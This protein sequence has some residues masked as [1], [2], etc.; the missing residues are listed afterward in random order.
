[1][2]RK[3]PARRITRAGAVPTKLLLLAVLVAL[4]AA[5]LTVWLLGVRRLRARHAASQQPFRPGARHL[6]IGFITNFWDTFG[7]G[8]FA[9]TTAAFK[10]WRVV[11]DE[12][13]PGTLNVGHTLPTVIQALVFIVAIH[14]ETMT[15]A[16]MIA[17]A[18][19]GAW[20]GAGVVARLARRN[21]QIGMGV[22]L[23]GAAAIVLAQLLALVPSGNAAALSGAKL[24]I[25][26]ST[27]AVLGALMT[28][29]VGLYAPCMVLV[30]LLGMDPAGAFP[31]M[32]GSCAFLMPVAGLRF[33]R[34]D[35][36]DVRAALGLTLG[37]PIAVLLAIWLLT[38]LPT[39][40]VRAL[41]FVVILYNAVTMLRSAITESR[42]ERRSLILDAE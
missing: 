37:G 20:F 14:V 8:S 2:G 23:L 16:L 29:G 5:F 15:L 21:V 27:N 6:G 13:I 35:A 9:T 22:A 1:M 30:S 36:Y 10:L 39:T 34:R 24:A 12:Q 7:I 4:T 40:V 31:I 18:C 38:S 28:L 33:I 3:E 19:A 25:G 41:V 42:A 32:M 11:R 17:A 26:I